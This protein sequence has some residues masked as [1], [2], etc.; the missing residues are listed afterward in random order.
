LSWKK[1]IKEYLKK[2]EK[3]KDNR[4]YNQPKRYGRSSQ[5]GLQ[6]NVEEKV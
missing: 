6:I 3:F 5:Y 1:S 4:E 2:T